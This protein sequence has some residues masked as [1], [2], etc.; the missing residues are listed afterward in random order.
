MNQTSAAVAIRTLDDAVVTYT[1]AKGA[2]RNLTVH[3]ALF[4]D[5]YARASLGNLA[6]DSAVRYAQNGRYR[7]ASEIIAGG[8][9]SLYKFITERLKMNPTANKSQFTTLAIAVLN[10]DLPKSG[11]FSPKQLVI[12]SMVYDICRAV[13]IEWASAP[14]VIEQIPAAEP[15]PAPADAPKADEPALM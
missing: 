5:K 11:K 4:G 13:G 9:P 3:G 6:V 15:A 8:F 1:T 10:A 2:E 7:Q 12:R 14:D